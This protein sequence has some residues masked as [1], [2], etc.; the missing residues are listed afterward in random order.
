MPG[1]LIDSIALGLAA[2]SMTSASVDLGLGLLGVVVRR[3]A[4]M[5]PA[6]VPA[7]KRCG[8]VASSVTR[9]PP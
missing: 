4:D 3:D 5:V 6:R 2:V 7:I 1:T 8:L 9:L